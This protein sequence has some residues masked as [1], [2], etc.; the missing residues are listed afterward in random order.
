MGVQED[1]PWLIIAIVIIAVLHI[2]AVVRTLVPTPLLQFLSL[3]VIHE[4]LLTMFFKVFWLAK[5]L[6]TST[7]TPYTTIRPTKSVK[8]Q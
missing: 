5:L 1:H 4:S 6:T 3:I 7:S 8:G 2:A